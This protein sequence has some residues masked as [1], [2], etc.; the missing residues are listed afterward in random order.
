MQIPG[1]QEVDKTF[2]LFVFIGLLSDP[3][4]KCIQLLKAPFAYPGT[5]KQSGNG[6]KIQ[7]EQDGEIAMDLCNR[8]E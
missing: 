4:R 2:N 8:S 1:N 7:K 6:N 3:F 5:K